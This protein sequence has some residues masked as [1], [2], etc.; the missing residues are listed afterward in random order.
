MKDNC[1]H[2][3]NATIIQQKSCSSCPNSKPKKI[4]A[5]KCRIFNIVKS[6]TCDLCSS[7]VRKGK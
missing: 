1:K 4:K 3:I 7:F 2:F 6:K 5:V